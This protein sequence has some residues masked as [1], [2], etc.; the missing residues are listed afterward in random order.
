MCVAVWGLKERKSEHVYV[1]VNVWVCYVIGLFCMVCCTTGLNIRYLAAL[2]IPL[3]LYCLLYC[4][5]GKRRDI[6]VCWR[7]DNA[8]RYIEHELLSVKIYI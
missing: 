3:F 6:V 8:I 2:T 5:T 4:T 7:C 1:Y